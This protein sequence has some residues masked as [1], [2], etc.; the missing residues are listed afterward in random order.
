MQQPK[1]GK[2]PH[3]KRL[4]LIKQSPHYNNAKDVF[5]NIHHTPTLTEGYSMLDVLSN[6]FFKS[7]PDQIPTESIPSVKTNLK[8]LDLNNDILVWF[9]HSSY[10][11]QIEGIRFLIDPVFSGNASP[12]PESVK[13]FKGSNIYTVEDMPNIDYLLI[14]HDHYDHLDYKTIIGLKD[15]VKQVICGLGVGSHFEY[16][17]YN[18]DI[19]T[20]KDWYETI[21]LK[22]N[23]IIHTTPA[24]HFSGRTFKRNNTLWQSYVLETPSKKLFL[25]GD[26]GYDSHFKAIGDKFGPFDLAIME[27]GQYNKAWEAIHTLPEQVLKA[28]TDLKAKRIFPVHSSKFVL[29]LHPWNEPLNEVFRISKNYN[30]PLVTPIIGEKV[31]L[32]D[33]T[34]IFDT[35]WKDVK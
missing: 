7:H 17:G 5:E 4:E 30:I 9:G 1:F 6:Q 16:W 22:N 11:L 33:S 8:A 2:A 23:I 19:I 35:W 26:S 34:Q 10:L 25:G 21:A 31:M 24:R 14:S 32:N 15:K 29:A 3:G 27:N 28:A 20:E 18:P 13:A 12:I